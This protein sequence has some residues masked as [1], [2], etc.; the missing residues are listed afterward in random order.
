MA[1]KII[2]TGS[3]LGNLEVTNLALYDR[4][5]NFN[6]TR[7]SE[8][9]R[10]KGQIV[11]GLTPPQVFDLWVRQVCGVEKRYFFTPEPLPETV[12]QGIAEYMGYHAAKQALERAGIT[13]NT[14]D[15]VIFCSFTSAQLIPNPACTVA[16]YLGTGGVAA[17]HINTACSGFLDGLGLAN[18]LIQAG[19]YK[20]ILV[21][22]SECMSSHIDF[23][24]LTTAIL[25]GDGASAAILEASPDASGILS[26]TSSTHY[27]KDMLSMDYGHPLQMKGGAY[28]QRSAVN[29]M[30]ATL[31]A[32]LQKVNLNFSHLSYLI[33]H[34]ANLRILRALADKIGIAPEKMLQSIVQTGNVS[35]ASIGIGLDW[36]MQGQ[37]ESLQF[38]QGDLLGLTVVGGG[39]TSSGMI[40]RV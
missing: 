33:P 32:A 10:K 28:V 3:F 4:V 37:I 26:F 34:Q 8:T 12:P 18:T 36:A 11:E 2:T 21:V 19:A 17:L 16:H 20:R 14:L 6:L 24:D 23:T 5:S 15:Y 22:A 35:A 13:A 39:Y 25:F 27:N 30:A 1:A 7:A 9:L 40:Y 31:E 29:A 38:R